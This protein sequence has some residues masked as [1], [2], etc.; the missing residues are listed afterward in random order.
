[1]ASTIDDYK[2]IML[3]VRA[4]KFKPVYLLHGEEGFFI[5]RIADEIEQLALQDHERDFNQSILY[6]RDVDPD[7]V[8][9]TCLRY[10]MMAERQLVVVRELQNWRV[11]QLDK[12]EAYMAKPTPTTLLVLCY[13]HKKVD[14]R[15]TILKTIQKS[16]GIVF[17]SDKVKDD[18]LPDVL[19][20]FAKGMKRK[21]GAAE[22]QLLANHLGSDLAKAVKEVEKLCLVTEEGGQITADA[23]QRFVGISK[24][25]NIFELQ[26]A[27][28]N[29]NAER[30]QRIANHFAADPKEYPLVLTIG[31]LNTYFAKLAVVHALQG[32]GPQE[33][34]AGLKV[35][36]FFIKDYVAQARNYPLPKIAEIQRY[37]RQC[38]LRS[39]GLGGDGSDHGELLRELLAR[40][41]G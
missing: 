14:G 24:D 17:A 30:A 27:I 4:G 23:I 26:N 21:L 37:L 5:D 11:D 34:A 6:G 39:K 31:L 38:D 12:L 16:G 3:D 35:N 32:K 20:G 18:K 25:Y 2:K 40:I 9:D 28:G 29:R 7:T 22:A 15:K 36:P 19:M 13:K 1:M 8:K 41:M 33:L 10:P